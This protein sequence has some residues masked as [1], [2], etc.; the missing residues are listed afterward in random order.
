MSPT[1]Y[2]FSTALVVC[3][4][5]GAVLFACVSENRQ[6]YVIAALCGLMLVLT[7]AW[8]AA[9]QRN[10]ESYKEEHSCRP[11]DETRST[12]VQGGRA[13]VQVQE[14]LWVCADGEQFWDAV[15]RGAGGD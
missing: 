15:P 14:H 12:T 6:R 2:V 13:V 5:F 11:T 4:V 9:S 8:M 1:D 7:G 3:C 10:W